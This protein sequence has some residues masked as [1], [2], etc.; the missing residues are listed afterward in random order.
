MA[1]VLC[2]LMII[3][4]P[5]FFISHYGGQIGDHLGPDQL[6]AEQFFQDHTTRGEII[7]YGIL[8]GTKYCERYHWIIFD[9]LRENDKLLCD[10]SSFPPR[11]VTVGSL[12]RNRM[13]YHYNEPEFVDRV[14]SWLD[15]SPDYDYVYANPELSLY[16]S[17]Q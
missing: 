12:E 4:L 3:Y 6:A 17:E 2:A 15:S 16:I 14:W 7:N 13:N 8:G 11:Y 5:L 1:I 10:T 9:Q